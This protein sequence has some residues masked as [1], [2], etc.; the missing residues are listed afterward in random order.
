LFAMTI[1][2]PS[3]P[4]VAAVDPPPDGLLGEELLPPQATAAA[5]RS[6]ATA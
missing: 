3:V 6:R 5:A 2:F 4:Q 1:V